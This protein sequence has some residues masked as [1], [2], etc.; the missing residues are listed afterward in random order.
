M[1]SLKTWNKDRMASKT[2]KAN[3]PVWIKKGQTAKVGPTPSG[4]TKLADQYH[5]LNSTPDLVDKVGNGRI[6]HDDM[7]NPK[8]IASK[9]APAMK[10]AM[11][12]LRKPK[13]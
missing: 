11:G 9:K 4:L 12:K 2:G 10:P 8:G 7:N 1:A 13:G 5:K 6:E 3:P